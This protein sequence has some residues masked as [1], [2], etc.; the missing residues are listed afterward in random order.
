MAAPSSPRVA[1][2]VM[3]SYIQT[4]SARGITTFGFLIIGAFLSPHEFGLFALVS[5]W[6]MLSELL[7]EQ[8]ISQMIVQLQELDDD[9]LTASLILSFS[10][11]VF[12]AAAMYFG[13]GLIS[14]FFRAD[15]LQPFLQFAAIYPIIIGLYAIPSG[16][17]KRELAFKILT[18]RTVIASSVAMVTG[19]GLALG[20]MGT[21]ALILQSLVFYVFSAVTLWRHTAWRP[22]TL[23]PFHLLPRVARFATA[24]VTTKVFGYLETRGIELLLGRMVGVAELGLFAFASKIALTAFQTVVSPLLEVTFA[25]LARSRESKTAGAT[26]QKVLL[27]IACAPAPILFGLS[28]GAVALLHGVY[29]LKWVDAVL[30]LAVLVAAYFLRAFVYVFG[31]SLLAL[32]HSREAVMIDGLRTVICLIG[33]FL[34][35]KSGH[36][37]LGAAL[38]YFTASLVILPIAVFGINKV[39]DIPIRTLFI[40][41]LK[42][43]TAA[44]FCAVLF[45][46]LNV[47]LSL[48]LG[49]VPAAALA[50]FLATT[51]F[52]IA[53][54]LLNARLLS[55][56]LRHHAPHGRF[57]RFHRPLSAIS[58]AVVQCND[59][60]WLVWF[61]ISLISGSAFARKPKKQAEPMHLIVPTDPVEPDGS[62]GNQAKLL[63]LGILIDC[64]L[65]R[66]VVSKRFVGGGMFA[67][68]QFLPAWDDILAGW[69]LGRAASQISS[70]YI[71]DAD[72]KGSHGSSLTNMQKVML[73]DVYARRGIQSTFTAFS[74][75]ARTSMRMVNA[76][77][78]L[79][80]TVRVCLRDEESL[81]KF[82][83]RVGRKATLVADLAFLMP[84]RMDS[85]DIERVKA[86]AVQQRNAG[87]RMLGINVD[88]LMMSHLRL[89]GEEA[90]SISVAECCRTLLRERVSIVLIPYDFRP[91]AADVRVLSKARGILENEDTENVILLSDAL[92]AWEIK[93][94][95]IQFDLILSARI[96]LTI[97]AL[98]V[99]TPVCGI[100]HQGE[101]EVLFRL[102]DFGPDIFIAQEAALDA[103]RL[104]LFILGHLARAHSY[105][106]KI[107]VKLPRIV[108]LARENI[109]TT[110]C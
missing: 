52:L 29:G 78:C 50:A 104:A 16:L 31:I 27:L 95:C 77:R 87:R 35:F 38:A 11:A 43:V 96:P 14:D 4:F 94:A 45:V 49:A 62:L 10:L 1:S 99:G 67:E 32:R 13:A 73:A 102:F 83:S 44:L 79:P 75:N 90:L 110:I 57:A 5:A 108:E 7:C 72:M 91:G 97:C 41:P 12:F 17:L 80:A 8:A 88:P 58:E 81:L 63:G 51:L 59:W 20:G 9:H 40:V 24:N 53:S 93:A 6:L 107:L 60:L 55:D 21:W 101:F 42:A 30:P 109:A 100:Q 76:F 103:Q 54:M 39:T 89:D 22:R 26:I 85:M 33:A 47:K 2:S 74:F 69:K 70:L 106:T 68:Q 71:M 65:I 48:S 37:A 19:I 56:L 23:P 84:L 86:W 82:E 15:D 25:R 46:G 92:T 18:Q 36:G 105:R 66:I 28:V 64:K 98:S 3:W 61:K 34:L